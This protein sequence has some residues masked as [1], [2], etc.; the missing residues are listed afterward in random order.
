MLFRNWTFG[1]LGDTGSNVTSGDEL[2][3][4]QVSH[5]PRECDGAN[6]VLREV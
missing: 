4:E 5:E 2:K 3:I 1:D 6:D